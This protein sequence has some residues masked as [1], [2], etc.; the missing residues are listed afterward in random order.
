MNNLDC[1]TK[2]N[3]LSIDGCPCFFNAS[4]TLEHGGLGARGVT[5]TS[6]VV[7]QSQDRSFDESKGHCR[8]EDRRPV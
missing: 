5:A 6:K 2:G 8:D 4:F 7:F 3:R 1:T